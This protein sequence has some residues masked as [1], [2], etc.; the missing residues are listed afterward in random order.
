M[1]SLKEIFYSHMSATDRFSDR[2]V[3]DMEIYDEYFSKYRNTEISI[4][5]VG[6]GGGGGLQIWKK[7]FGDKAKIYGIDR[8]GDLLFEEDQ[9]QIF[10][11]DQRDRVF[12]KETANKIKEIDILIDDGG[13]EPSGQIP[14]FEELMPYVKEG[15][16][17]ACEDLHDAYRPEYANNS[18]ID[19][20]K[21]KV[22]NLLTFK[23]NSFSIH[24]YPGLLIIKK[25]TKNLSIG[26]SS[27]TVGT[28][29]RL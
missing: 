29:P 28:Y 4:V 20:W 21:L 27:M 17:Y 22:D 11:G 3:H 12:L 15:G 13:H 23:D 8:R 25:D 14:T 24:F 16:I 26:F 9:I 19:Y 6:I 10:M 1:S 5:E 7:Y 18:F 2:F